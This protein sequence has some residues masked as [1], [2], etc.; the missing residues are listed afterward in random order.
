MF[1]S[2]RFKLGDTVWHKAAFAELAAIGIVNG[3]PLNMVVVGRVLNECHAGVQHEYLLASGRDGVLRCNDEEVV[4]PDF[5]LLKLA[6]KENR[7]LNADEFL[8]S[9]KRREP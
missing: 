5:E 1:D 8:K 9:V 6:T 7:S 3:R 4:A 2:M